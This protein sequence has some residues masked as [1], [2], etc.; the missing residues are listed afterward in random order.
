[1][2]ASTSHRTVLR[3]AEAEHVRRSR[4]AGKRAAEVCGSVRE[5]RAVQEH[6][7][8]SFAAQKSLIARSSSSE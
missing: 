4:Q 1:M 5:P 3:A 2:T 8:N 6:T 7:R